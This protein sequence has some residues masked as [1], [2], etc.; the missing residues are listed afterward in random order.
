[1]IEVIFGLS[2]FLIVL[3]VFILVFNIIND[4]DDDCYTTTIASCIIAFIVLVA[5][6]LLSN[7]I[8]DKPTYKDIINK[9]AKY[10]E[11]LYIDDNDTIKIYEIVIINED[12]KK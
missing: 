7:N 10:N 2:L 4:C 5:I 8:M 9:K 1:M 12:N 3:I 6:A 11:V